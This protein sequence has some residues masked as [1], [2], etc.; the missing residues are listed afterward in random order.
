M[1]A[2]TGLLC[3]LADGL[4]RSGDVGDSLDQ[5]VDDRDRLV[6][7]T[8]ESTC[9]FVLGHRRKGLRLVVYPGGQ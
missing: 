5:I 7:P 9:R 1:S 8:T 4:G 3:E 6:E 2:S